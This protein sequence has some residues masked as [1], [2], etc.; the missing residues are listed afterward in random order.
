MLKKK[1]LGQFSK[2]YRTFYPKFVTN[3]PKKYGF[4][5]RDPRSGIQGTE[6]TYSGIPVQG[7]KSHRIPDPDL[8]HW[9]VGSVFVRQH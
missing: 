6:K 8:Q 2:N 3:L 9:S 4:G 5:I 7:S 1:K